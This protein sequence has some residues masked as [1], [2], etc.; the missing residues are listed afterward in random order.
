MW[1]LSFRYSIIPSEIKRVM[2][3]M[4]SSTTCMLA[5]TS[6]QTMHYQGVCHESHRSR[7]FRRRH[8]RGRWFDMSILQ[9]PKEGEINRAAVESGI[10]YYHDDKNDVELMSMNTKRYREV[11]QGDMSCYNEDFKM[12]E[13]D[14]PEKGPAEIEA[15]VRQ[16]SPRVCLHR[17]PPKPSPAR[18]SK[19]SHALGGN[20]RKEAGENKSKRPQG[21][22]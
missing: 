7:R 1:I 11:R 12:I 2:R 3:R 16:M 21:F 4:F 17:H 5:L 10:V 8:R 13:E 19:V 18:P 20:I 15:L 9:P 6:S 22:P 14:D